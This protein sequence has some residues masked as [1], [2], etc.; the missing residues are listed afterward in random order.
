MTP[1]RMA[2]RSLLTPL[3][4]L[5]L[6]AS[7]APLLGATGAERKRPRISHG[8][9]QL[10]ASKR[11]AILAGRN[12]APGDRVAGSVT[13]RNTGKLSGSFRLRG[14]V[15]GS[16]PLATHLFLTVRERTRRTT[17]PVYSGTLARFRGVRLGTI[18][19]GQARRFR[20]AVRFDPRAPNSLQ[21]KRTSAS[22][23]WRA[24]QPS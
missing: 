4:I 22:F 11:G 10:V 14:A 7:A 1:G 13:I 23:T 17:R 5:A 6:L 24:V 19:R 16:R 21:G 9:L 3:L 12:L 20:F 15:R 18:R 8:R 2:L